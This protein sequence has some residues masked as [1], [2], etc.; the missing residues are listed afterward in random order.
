M[1]QPLGPIRGRR[2]G[3]GGRGRGSGRGRV[4]VGVRA[5]ELGAVVAVGF[6]TSR[7]GGRA[8]RGFGPR[9]G[10]GR[11]G[12]G[13][14]GRGRRGRGRRG[15]GRRGSIGARARAAR[16]RSARLRDGV[17]AC[18]VFAFRGDVSVGGSRGVARSSRGGRGRTRGSG[19]DR[20]RVVR[21]AGGGVVA[22][23]RGRGRGRG[24]V[25]A[26]A[27]LAHGGGDHARAAGRETRREGRARARREGR[28]VRIREASSE[29]GGGARASRRETRGV[30][31]D[32]ARRD[33]TRRGRAPT[34]ARHHARRRHRREARRRPH[35]RPR[36]A[37]PR[38]ATRR[39]LCPS[40]DKSPRAPSPG[41]EN[42][43]RAPEEKS[44]APTRIRGD[45]RDRT[46]RLPCART[47]L[48]RRGAASRVC[49][50]DA[51]GR[52]YLFDRS[53]G[54]RT[55]KYSFSR[56]SWRRYQSK[57][58]VISG[59][60]PAPDTAGLG[61]RRA[62]ARPAPLGTPRGAH[63]VSRDAVA[64]LGGGSVAGCGPPTRADRRRAR[65][66]ERPRQS[67]GVRRAR[68]GASARR[69]VVFGG[70]FAI[71]RPSARRWL[72]PRWTT[73]PVF[74]APPR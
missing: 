66:R 44:R 72:M 22:R 28:R 3:G 50:S 53:H 16:A 55:V 40:D 31:R 5:A 51:T 26:L 61:A 35:A 17:F 7:G 20:A 11:R 25:P 37:R 21:V 33:A 23:R 74:R 48:S 67:R 13:R 27:G 43:P 15:R 45:A 29:R 70:Q 71:A 57:H 41:W 24:L 32:D 12:R 2:G 60:G 68:G 52:P 10:R 69:V 54:S 64:R 1:R 38:A 65:P 30:T 36:R 9:R 34:R 8:S 49:A 58:A 19:R 14:R 59:S 47:V 73:R 4:R 46:R 39:D 18:A 56:K 42:A 62:S 6:A 63:A